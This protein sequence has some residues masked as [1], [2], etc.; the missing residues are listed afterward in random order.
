MTDYTF[1]W[2]DYEAGG[3]NPRVDRPM[4]FAGIRTNH[5]FEVIGK[6]LNIFCQ[7][8]PDY[9]PHPE[10][11]LITG[12]TPQ[13][14]QRDGY[15]EVQFAEK[16]AAELSQA[17]TISV[18]YNNISY[19]D[20]MTRFLFYRNFIDPYAHS[21]ANNNSRWDLLELVRAC[22]ALRPEGI[23]W[24]QNQ[25]GRVS[26][27]LEH[28]TAANHLNHGKAHDALADV[29]ATIALAKLIY[30]KQPKLFDWAFEHRKKAKL[31]A[32]VNDSLVH[33]KPLVHVSG[34]YGAHAGYCNWVLP[35][36][37]HPEQ[38]NTLIAW[39]LDRNPSEWQQYDATTLNSLLYDS[40]AEPNLRPGLVKIQLNQCP[41]LAPEKVLSN[42]RAEQFGLSRDQSHSYAHVLQQHPDLRQ[43]FVDAMAIVRE[44]DTSS[45]DVDTA[46][47]S[48]G[49][50]SPQAQSH[51][52]L[53]R[54]LPPEQLADYPFE[55]DDHRF[56]ALLFRFRARNYPATLTH[57]EQQQWLQHC[58]EQLQHGGTHRLSIDEFLLALNTAAERVQ[59]DAH[60]TRLLKDLYQWA[61]SL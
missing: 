26:L 58:R 19:D 41:F 31:L 44:Y 47:Y 43:R 12:I 5:K 6:P 8:S 10:A 61:Q 60:K 16:I 15:P 38:S 18:G 51:A 34:F 9:L 11:C 35:L 53:I 57:S 17:N 54:N 33:A 21:W 52:Q 45:Q 13:Q 55:F 48:G 39:R 7:L 50:L 42:E 4:Q 32:L 28:L 27:K 49:L 3:V 29:Y 2:H 59:N 24:P 23:E 25:E 56:K 22:Y 30:E 14:C 36:A 46:L 40:T 20:E 1:Y 37:F